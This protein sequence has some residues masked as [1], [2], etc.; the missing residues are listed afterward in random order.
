MCRF[1]WARLNYSALEFSLKFCEKTNVV[2]S[3]S[4]SV[5]CCDCSRGIA[6]ESFGCHSKWTDLLALFDPREENLLM[7]V[8]SVCATT[9]TAFQS[10][11][12]DLPDCG[13]TSP[14]NSDFFSTTGSPAYYALNG[15]N[16]QQCPASGTVGAACSNA[17]SSL[18][19]VQGQGFATGYGFWSLLNMRQVPGSETLCSSGSP[20]PTCTS[21]SLY[22][23]VEGILNL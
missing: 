9:I 12:V 13:A 6:S 20:P 19:N 21:N 23:L 5:D 18:V 7:T 8:Y 1:G 4:S 2:D 15:W 3:P 11:Q 22:P 17:D 16:F 10:G 14:S